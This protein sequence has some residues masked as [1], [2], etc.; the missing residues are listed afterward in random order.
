MIQGFVSANTTETVSVPG[1]YATLNEALAAIESWYIPASSYVDI[2]L[3]SGSHTSTTATVFR[4]PCGERVRIK[5]TAF[6][7]TSIT[8]LN[9]SVSGSPGN[10]SVTLNVASVA[11]M[12]VNDYAV[13][14][15]RGG[16]GPWQIHSGCWKIT[17]VDTVNKRITVTNTAR[18][19]SFPTT[20]LTTGT[21]NVLRTVLKYNGC[22]GIRTEGSK[23]GLLVNV[24]VVGNRTGDFSGIT[25][26]ALDG[27]ADPAKMTGTGAIV[28]G[29][30]VGVCGFGA[31][32]VI[33][34]NGSFIFANSVASSN[35]VKYGFYAAV[36]AGIQARE[37]AG[38]GND[39]SGVISDYGGSAWV[40]GS[41]FCGNGGN[42]MLVFNGGHII[43][44]EVVCS[45][46]VAR[47]IDARLG[48]ITGEL[49]T[50]SYNGNGGVLCQNG[51]QLAF[52]GST[53]SNNTGPGVEAKRGGV[54]RGEDLVASNNTTIGIHADLNGYIFADGATTAGNTTAQRRAERGGIIE[55][56]VEV[57]AGRTLVRATIS[58]DQS[59]APSTETL[60][61]YDAEQIDANGE[62]NAG[63]S[64]FTANGNRKLRL[65]A[66]IHTAQFASPDDHELRVKKNGTITAI[67]LVTISNGDLTM[68]P[69]VV[70][71]VFQ[72]APGDTLAIY[73]YQDGGTRTI[74]SGT[75]RSRLL[76]EEI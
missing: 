65:T 42:G 50:C 56:P 39:E 27:T 3:A 57:L 37:A 60:V 67:S 1:D 48:V 35:N 7:Q 2:V 11:G 69:L 30:F 20:T 18:N 25:A 10:Y 33:A 24:A 29:E 36:A 15:A 59:V 6:I 64:I 28:C 26:A 32:G 45:A 19:A 53:A 62:F 12:A 34:N 52:D 22:D 23:L 46:N 47:G 55:D 41:H 73:Y 54:I 66:I 13:L 17:N 71:D 9:G 4:H 44:N 61:H 76:I 68:A 58:N 31:N 49:A 74:V 40:A 14:A 51:S 70:S 16:T 43:A 75:T 21:L 63:T 5:G 72:V 38:N 8:S